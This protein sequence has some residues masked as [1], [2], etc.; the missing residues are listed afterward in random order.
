MIDKI[1][2]KVD[3][4][5]LHG[6]SQYL[7]KMISIDCYCHSISIEY[8]RNGVY[9]WETDASN[10]IWKHVT[11]NRRERITRREISVKS[12][13]LPMSYLSIKQ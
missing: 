12:R 3:D 7:G 6:S 2:L 13:V 1:S 5:N 8:K 10:A 11:Q 4:I 9:P